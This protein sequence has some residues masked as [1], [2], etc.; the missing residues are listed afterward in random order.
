MIDVKK[1]IIEKM[2]RSF[3]YDQNKNSTQDYSNYNFV[4]DK[5]WEDYFNNYNIGINIFVFRNINFSEQFKI[6]AFNFNARFVFMNCVFENYF[7]IEKSAH[8]NFQ[9]NFIEC[10]FQQSFIIANDT[11]LESVSFSKN[12]KINSLGINGFDNHIKRLELWGVK[13]EYF[14][15]DGLSCN[16]FKIYASAFNEFRVARYRPEIQNLFNNFQIKDNSFEKFEVQQLNFQKTHFESNKFNNTFEMRELN[17][18][19]NVSESRQYAKEE[20]CFYLSNNEFKREANVNI[21]KIKKVHLKNNQISEIFKIKGKDI[22]TTEIEMG[23]FDAGGVVFYDYSTKKINI[24]GNNQKQNI[25]FE[26][27]NFNKLNIENFTNYSNVNFYNCEALKVEGEKSL[28]NINNSHLGKTNF[29]NFDFNSFDEIK[30]ENSVLTEII[31]SNVLWFE[32][33]K[34]N[35]SSKEK[36]T[37]KYLKN[38]R[39]IYRQ[40][41][42]ATEKQGDKIQ[43]LEF[44]AQELKVFKKEINLKSLWYLNDK[45]I[46]WLSWTNNFG[47]N[48]LRAFGLLLGSTII[49]AGLIAF[50]GCAEAEKSNSLFSFFS[51]VFSEKPKQ[52]GF[53]GLFCKIFVN[54]FYISQPLNKSLPLNLWGEILDIL[55]KITFAFFSVQIISAFRKYVKT[56]S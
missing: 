16:D 6:K 53:W 36:K 26:N 5:D 47:L 7:S 54:L 32:P 20:E 34:L 35:T 18:I 27:A 14:N 44:Q 48:W 39:E 43:S 51:A 56:S 46:F 17:C 9:L 2:E 25:N 10:N 19:D 22:E 31:A 30:I 49:F 33:K 55:H 24:S 12:C 28:I 42:Q 15:I 37:I 38:Q 41:K 13:V 3:Y 52:L 29:F 50:F 1:E 40:L 21:Q 11:H 23:Y 45:L 8:I 4:C